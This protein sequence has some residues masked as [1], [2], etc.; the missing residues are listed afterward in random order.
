MVA[1]FRFCGG[2]VSTSL[3]RLALGARG[4]KHLAHHRSDAV[5]SFQSDHLLPAS[6]PGSHTPFRR[7]DDINNPPPEHLP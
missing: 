3:S 6:R 4:S 5:G 1:L 2:R 7:I